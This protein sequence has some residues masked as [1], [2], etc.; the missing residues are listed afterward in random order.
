VV[1]GFGAAALAGANKP[2]ARTMMIA[3]ENFLM[4]IDFNLS[5]SNKP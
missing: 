2:A 3:A 5:L 1:P 4:S